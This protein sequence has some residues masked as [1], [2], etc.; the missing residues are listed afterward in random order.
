MLTKLRKKIWKF[1]SNLYLWSLRN[2][3]KMDIG[4]D[5]IIAY[6]ARLDKSINPKGIRIG[7]ETT[8]AREAIILSHDLSREINLNTIIGERCFIG[9]RAIILPGITLGN[10]VIVGAGSIVTKSFPSNCIIAGNPAKII[11]ENIHCRKYGKLQQ[12][13]K[14]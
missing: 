10:E 9:V 11:K 2:L 14:D 5:V 7:K 3:Y 13:N 12:E 8:I 1:R 6:S 4:E